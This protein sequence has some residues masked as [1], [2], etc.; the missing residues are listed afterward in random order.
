[1][2]TVDLEKS[3]FVRM[4]ECYSCAQTKLFQLNLNFFHEQ[5][6]YKEHSCASRVHY[7]VWGGNTAETVNNGK[8]GTH[9]NT[10]TYRSVSYCVASFYIN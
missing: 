9:T 5:A 7:S 4:S 1:M 3:I 10:D 2:K 8:H 6:A